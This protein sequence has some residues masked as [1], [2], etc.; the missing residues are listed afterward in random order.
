MASSVYINQS[1]QVDK[2]FGFSD[3]DRHFSRSTD[4]P[5]PIRPSYSTFSFS[6]SRF[7]T[8]SSGT[9]Y[10]DSELSPIISGLEHPSNSP[11]RDSAQL[12]AKVNAVMRYKEKKKV[13]RY[14]K[15]I[16]Y[17]SR[18]TRADVRKRVKGRFVKAEGYE[19]D[20]IDVARS[21]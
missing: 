15:Q 17:A 10:M 20:T 14:E 16:R 5:R 2:D 8:E 12:E 19:S 21:Y 7:G 9:D 13:R 3:Q 4:C 11:D 18:K 6:L 1:G